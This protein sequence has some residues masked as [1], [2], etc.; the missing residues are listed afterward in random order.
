MKQLAILA[1]LVI[2]APSAMAADPAC[3]N[4]PNL[5]GECYTTHGVV[6]MSADALVVLAVT[7]SSGRLRLSVS[8]PSASSGSDMPPKISDILTRDLHSEIEGEFDVCPVRAQISLVD[9]AVCIES[10]SHMSV[11]QGTP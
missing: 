11:R 7:G 3:R 8:A 5:I 10:V 1:M 4:N 6:L 2:Q 9:G